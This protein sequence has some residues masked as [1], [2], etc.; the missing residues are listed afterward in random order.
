VDVAEAEQAA[1]Q[2]AAGT[3]RARPTKGPDRRAPIFW[4]AHASRD[5][6]GPRV[7]ANHGQPGMGEG[8]CVAAP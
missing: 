8:A 1:A 7:G 2:R 3:G 6:G 5:R 4:R